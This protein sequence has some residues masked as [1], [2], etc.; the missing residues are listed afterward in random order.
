MI[1]I[2]LPRKL[3]CF[4]PYLLWMMTSKS[5]SYCPSTDSKSNWKSQTKIGKI[6]VLSTVAVCLTARDKVEGC[7]FHVYKC[8]NDLTHLYHQTNNIVNMTHCNMGIWLA[9][10]GHMIHNS[11]IRMP[12]WPAHRFSHTT[13]FLQ[14]HILWATY[15]WLGSVMCWQVCWA[16]FVFCHPWYLD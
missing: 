10:E 4:V 8:M 12:I 3:H 9:N 11:G 7:V 1:F 14:Q 2:I 15:Y 16:D 6:T 5:Y 13:D